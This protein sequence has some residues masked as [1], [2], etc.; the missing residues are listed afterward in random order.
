MKLKLVEN[1]QSGYKWFSSWAFLVIVFLATTP[2][3]SE[4][5]ALFPITVQNK[6]TALVAVCGLILRFVKQKDGSPPTIGGANGLNSTLNTATVKVQTA[7][8]GGYTAWEHKN[9]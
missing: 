2:L 1:W 6:L 8:K 3:P 5:V 9:E 4:L 7:P